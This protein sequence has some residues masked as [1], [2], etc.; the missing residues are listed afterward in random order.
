MSQQT[1]RVVL[2]TMKVELKKKMLMLGSKETDT[3]NNTDI[4][5]TDKEE[6]LLKLKI[7]GRETVSS[8]TISKWFN[9]KTAWGGD[10][11]DPLWFFE[12]CIF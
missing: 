2:L 10:Q 1:K 7:M 12:K 4:Y 6:S 9:P 3:I 8:Y 5:D 11:L